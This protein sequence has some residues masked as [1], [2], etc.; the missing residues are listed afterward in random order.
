MLAIGDGAVRFR[1][2]LERAGVAVPSDGSRV[3][4]VSALPDRERL[5]VCVFRKGVS[6]PSE[7][8]LEREILISLGGIAAEARHTGA[9][10]WDA[11]D[12]DL[13]YVRDLAVQ[14]ASPRQA[15]RL[16]IPLADRLAAMRAQRVAQRRGGD[17]GRR[18]AAAGARR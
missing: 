15:E 8:W 1:A 7:D 18:P 5:G 4:R 2:E 14:R 10:A 17:R 9:Y 11:A 16:E 12:R 3:H 13:Q 6:R